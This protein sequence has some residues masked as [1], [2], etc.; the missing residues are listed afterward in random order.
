MRAKSQSC[1]QLSSQD[2]L[3]AFV[4]GFLFFACPTRPRLELFHSPAT[5]MESIHIL[6]F[7]AGPKPSTRAACLPAWLTAALYYAHKNVRRTAATSS[8]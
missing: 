1:F 8:A 3:G 6:R 5:V 2:T 7:V 4:F